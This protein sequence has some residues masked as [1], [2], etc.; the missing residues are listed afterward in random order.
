MKPRFKVLAIIGLLLLLIGVSAVGTS[1]S[2]VENE[3][4]SQFVAPIMVVNTSFLNVRTGP[5]A[6]YS[7]LITVV[8]GTEFPVLGMFRDRVWYQVSTVAGVGWINSQFAL[9]RGDFRNVPLVDAP[10]IVFGT[11]L[12]GTV[13][14]SMDDAV[15]GQSFAGGRLWGVSVTITHPARSGPSINS[16]SPGTAFE[17]DNA[18]YTLIESTANE[19]SVWYRVLIPELGMTW[20]EGAKARFRPFACQLSAVV[21]TTNAAPT[22]GPDGSGT[23]DGNL[24][25]EANSEA[26]LLDNF[27]DS[28]YKVELIDGNTGWVPVSSVAI[29]DDIPSV[30]CTSGGVDAGSAAPGAV[31]TPGAP[32]TIP[33]QTGASLVAPRVVV[34]TGFLN[35]RS[36]PGAQYTVVTTVSGGTEL[37]V[38]GFAPDG[39]WYLVTGTF[40]QAWL[41]SEFALF[42][43]DGRGVPVIRNFNAAILSNPVATITNA[44][45]LYSAPNAGSNV[46]GAVS[47]PIQVPVVAR[48]ADFT[49]VQISTSIG[50]GWVRVTEVT[51]GGDANLIPIIGG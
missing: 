6:Q 46:V 51:L 28:Q 45:N 40:G 48:S 10:E 36:G 26:Y 25:V 23:L 5:G 11:V 27:N 31:G 15:F 24:Q 41:N 42:R 39:V 50:F 16:G 14:P 13:A 18:I 3:Q 8:G 4:Q 35:L 43:G 32:G 9:P 17:N 29:R 7:V 38:I 34:N 47:G 12:P 44:V 2:A 22:L 49:W 21:F 37:P 1:V 19:G 30:Y 33:G 20:I